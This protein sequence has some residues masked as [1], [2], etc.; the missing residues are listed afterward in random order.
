MSRNV[1]W[2]N[3]N[4][5]SEGKAIGDKALR[6]YKVENKRIRPDGRN[7]DLI[8]QAFQMAVEGVTQEDI[9]NWLNTEGYKQRGKIVA[10]NKQKVFEMLSDPSYTGC[11]I[12]CKT[13]V[14]LIKQDALFQPMITDLEFLRLRNVVDRKCSYIKKGMTNQMFSK[15]VFC[16]YC[17]NLMTLAISQ[18]SGKSKTRYL[19]IRCSKATRES[20]KVKGL[21]ETRGY[22]I[23]DFTYEVLNGGVG[24]GK[25]CL[26]NTSNRQVSIS[27]SRAMTWPNNNVRS[28]VK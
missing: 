12:Y 16:W 5:I 20:T 9:A 7:Y 28:N 18:S 24:I 27:R 4:I 10:M 21:R 26:I 3:V 11:Y 6:G 13:M 19:R 1:T 17:G 25:L 15:M 22:V 23:F 14:D 8:K 2:V